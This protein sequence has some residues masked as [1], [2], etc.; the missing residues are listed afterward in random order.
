MGHSQ[1]ISYE[2]TLA[3]IYSTF[4]RHAAGSGPRD[5]LAQ[6]ACGERVTTDQFTRSPSD[7]ASCK[8]NLKKIFEAIQDYGQKYKQLPNWLSDLHPEF[9]DDPKTF[10]LP[11]FTAKRRLPILA[12]WRER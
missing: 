5:H 8:V 9:V 12:G 10:I 7:A 2:P 6:L 4:V 3:V 11:L 1:T